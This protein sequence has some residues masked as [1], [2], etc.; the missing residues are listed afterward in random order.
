LLKLRCTQRA[1][2]REHD[3][4]IAKHH[5]RRDGG[6]AEPRC[7]LLLGFSVDLRKHHIWV[8]LTCGF[9]HRS[10]G[11]A[12]PAPGSPE[13]DDHDAVASDRAFK[14]LDGEINGCHGYLPNNL[15]KNPLLACAA[16]ISRCECLPAH[17]WLAG[18]D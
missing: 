9:K 8:P 11:A 4:A 2:L 1:G 6:D 14:V 15:A 10:K 17:H 13:I 12:R 3:D 18:T 5:E 7:E 16:S